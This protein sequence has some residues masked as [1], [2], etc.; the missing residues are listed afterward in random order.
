M[1]ALIIGGGFVSYI[2]FLYDIVIERRGAR[3]EKNEQKQT[4]H[5]VDILE[6]MYQLELMHGATL[7]EN[8]P[9]EV[10]KH[11]IQ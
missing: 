8:T 11:G 10:Y 6:R 4:E 7:I 3:L 9:S 2:G 5:M 1:L